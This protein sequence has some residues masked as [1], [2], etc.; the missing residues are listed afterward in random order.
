[1]VK[2]CSHSN[3]IEKLYIYGH[4]LHSETNPLGYLELISGSKLVVNLPFPILV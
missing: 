2:A 3:T 4:S 1:L